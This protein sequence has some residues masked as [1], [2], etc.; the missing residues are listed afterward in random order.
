MRLYL[1]NAAPGYTPAT[2]RG[3]WN[4][5]AATLARALAAA[6]AGTNTTAALAEASS[7]SN[8]NGLLGRWITDPIV[9]AGSLAGTARMIAGVRESASGMNAYFRIH[10]YVLAGSTDTVR[11]TLYANGVP[12][13]G[14]AAAEWYQATSG[15]QGRDTGVMELTAVAVQPG[16]RIVCEIGYQAQNTST[17]SFTGTLY[18]GGTGTGVLDANDTAVTTDPGWIDFSDLDVLMS[19]VPTGTPNDAAYVNAGTAQ[20]TTSAQ[21]LAVPVPSGVADDDFLILAAGNSSPDPMAVSGFT[22]LDD[23]MIGNDVQ[24]MFGWRRAASEPASY[25]VTGPTV[26]TTLAGAILAYRNVEGIRDWAATPLVDDAQRLGSLASPPAPSLA[27]V[28]STDLV[29]HIYV[30]GNDAASSAINWNPTL[31]STP[32]GWTSRV[33]LP[34][35]AASSGSWAAGLIVLEKRGSLEHPTIKLPGAGQWAVFT[36]ALIGKAAAPVGPEPGRNLLLAA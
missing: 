15:G 7:T 11:G 29:L 2:K 32:A 1:T 10:I 5:S 26:A 12:S 13:S 19:T 36:I 20:N 25:T 14:V 3:T 18:Y 27:G 22:E 8:Y 35:K 17:T 31:P 4:S 9:N 33:V 24:G 34:V 30:P 23:V 16:D 21:Q 6:P 28:T